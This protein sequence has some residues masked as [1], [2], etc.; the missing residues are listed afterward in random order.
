MRRCII[1]LSCII[2]FM[3]SSCSEGAIRQVDG[4]ETTGE[5]ETTGTTDSGTNGSEPSGTTSGQATNQ[6]TDSKATTKNQTTAKKTTTTAKKTTTTKKPTTT[7]TVG[8]KTYPLVIPNAQQLDVIAD[9][10]IRLMNEER[11]RLGI[12]TLQTEPLLKEAARIRAGEALPPNNFGHFRPDGTQFSTVIK[13]VKYGIPTEKQ[14]SND[15]INWTTIIDYDFGVAAEN[16]GA[17]NHSWD[18]SSDTFFNGYSCTTAEL[19]N[20]AKKL[21]EGWKNS[22]GHYRNMINSDYKKTGVGIYVYKVTDSPNTPVT[23]GY[24]FLRFIAITIFTSK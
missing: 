7:T 18:N 6:T 14:V 9:E 16:L 15:G 11:K 1:L 19:K 17:T 2:L 24:D 12:G 20:T 3:C 4:T 13:Q 5:S 22:S 21:Y 8:R 23:G 10:V